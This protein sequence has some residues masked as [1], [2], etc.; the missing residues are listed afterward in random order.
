MPSCLT[1]TTRFVSVYFHAVIERFRG[2]AL[3]AENRQK[4]RGTKK[5]IFVSHMLNFR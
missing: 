1:S 4:Q 3:A 5:W 2:G